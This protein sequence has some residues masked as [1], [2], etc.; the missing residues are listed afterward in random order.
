MTDPAQFYLMACGHV[1]QSQ[2][3]FGPS[4]AICFGIDPRS[5]IVVPKPRLDLRQ[6]R[7]FE[8][9]RKPVASSWDLPFF[10]YRPAEKT[11]EY[12]CG[13]RGWD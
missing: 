12:Y 11:D 7:C 4:C 1:A 2:G 9:S 8:C 3:R 5:E 10:S 6:A 13:C